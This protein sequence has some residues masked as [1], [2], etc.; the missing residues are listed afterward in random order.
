MSVAEGGSCDETT[1]K[2]VIRS[3]RQLRPRVTTWVTPLALRSP[4]VLL[5]RSELAA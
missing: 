1:A 3:H 2:K 4:T 5:E